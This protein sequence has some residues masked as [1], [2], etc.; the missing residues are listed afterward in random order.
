MSGDQVEKTVFGFSAASARTRPS[1]PNQDAQL[2]VVI[3]RRVR[4]ALLQHAI[5]RGMTARSVVLLLIRDAGIAEVDEAD[6]VD[7]RA[8]VGP[9][10]KTSR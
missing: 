5:G 4:Q 7:R 10:R 9:S 2:T 8:T 3:P 1:D 6:L